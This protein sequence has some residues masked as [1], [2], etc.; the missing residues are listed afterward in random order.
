MIR[1]R[2]RVTGVVQ[3]VGFRYY[4]VRRA[5]EFGL[6][7]WTRNTPD[8][9]VEIEAV[10]AEGPL[11]GFVEDIRIGPTAAHVTGLTVDRFEDDPG[12]E[13]FEIRF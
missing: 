5:R 3:G 2:I 7:G 8:G 13:G 11:N 12:H 6:T 9:S 1:L 10:G 4:V